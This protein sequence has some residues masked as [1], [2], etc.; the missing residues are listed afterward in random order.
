VGAR[1]KKPLAMTTESIQGCPC[2]QIPV[3]IKG[4]FVF[5]LAFVCDSAVLRASVVFGVCG[6][7]KLQVHGQSQADDVE[8]RP[9][10]G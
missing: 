3:G 2:N 8:S 10:I 7:V 1:R 6:D 5:A 9:N 4:H